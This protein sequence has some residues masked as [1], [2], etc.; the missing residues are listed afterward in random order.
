MRATLQKRAALMPKDILWQLILL[1]LSG[2]IILP[3]SPASS[4]GDY[5]VTIQTGVPVRMRDGVTLIADI[6]QPAAP[7]KFPVLLQ[8]TPY[9]RRD[10]ATGTLLA[11]H[12]YVV[13][14]QDT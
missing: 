5:K 13:V 2:T 12:G 10:A 1:I 6:Y 7:G 9:N 4:A 8:R 14:L 11:S 3:H